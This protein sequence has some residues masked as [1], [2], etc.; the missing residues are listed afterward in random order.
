MFAS[1]EELRGTAD[2]AC[3]FEISLKLRTES[4]DNE[5]EA[6]ALILRRSDIGADFWLLWIGKDGGKACSH[7]NL[8]ESCPLAEFSDKGVKGAF[9]SLH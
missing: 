4:A 9:G 8:S 7:R 5:R 1:N 6:V 2:R 3:L